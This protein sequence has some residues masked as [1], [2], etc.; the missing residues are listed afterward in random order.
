MHLEVVLESLP[1]DGLL[2]AS[3]ANLLYHTCCWALDP[4]LIPDYKQ[5]AHRWLFKSSPGP[6]LSRL[7]LLSSSTRPV[8][9]FSA[10]ERHLPLTGTKLYCLLT[11]AHRCE[12]L[13][14]GYYAALS[15]WELN[16]WP[17]N[18]KSNVLPLRHWATYPCHHTC[19]LYTGIYRYILLS[20][21]SISVG[22]KILCWDFGLLKSQ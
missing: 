15:R 18:H 10:K 7:P 22:L 17:I 21:I 16:P 8:V 20:H 2:S 11:E 13:A 14:Q 1:L 5:S 4:E 9:T 3:I 6:L 12:Q 19:I